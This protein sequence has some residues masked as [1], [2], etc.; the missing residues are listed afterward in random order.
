MSF[1]FKIEIG[2][3]ISNNEVFLLSRPNFQIVPGIIELKCSFGVINE[4]ICQQT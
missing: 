4:S 1:Q 3:N 2:D